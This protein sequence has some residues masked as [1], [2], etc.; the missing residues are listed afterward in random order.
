MMTV[1]AEV[2]VYRFRLKVED[3]SILNAFRDSHLVLRFEFD[4]VIGGISR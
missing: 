4:A 1:M 2:E 3:S